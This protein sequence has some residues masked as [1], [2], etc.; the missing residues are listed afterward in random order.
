[1]RL[2]AGNLRLAV[3]RLR[4]AVGNWPLADFL[5]KEILLLD[6]DTSQLPEANCQKLATYF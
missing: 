1:M 6:Y 2:A 3:L 5:A 4:L